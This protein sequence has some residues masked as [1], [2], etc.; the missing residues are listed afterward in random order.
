MKP[1]LLALLALAACVSAPPRPALDAPAPAF[2]PERFFAGPTHGDGH[3]RILLGGSHQVQVEGRGHSEADGTLVLDQTVRRDA[4]KPS[5]RQWRIHMTRPGHYAGTLSDARGRVTGDVQGN[6]LRLAFTGKDG[7]AVE[8]Y[9]YLQP[10]GQVALNRMT[11]RK[12]GVPVAALTETITRR[13]AA[14]A[15]R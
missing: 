4:A 3:L 1:V 15:S 10:G 6:R 11:V 14:P 5:T 7:F 13:D 8:Q 2:V 12:F 9:L